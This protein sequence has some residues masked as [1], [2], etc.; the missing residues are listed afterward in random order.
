MKIVEK[1]NPDAPITET[2]NPFK[3]DLITGELKTKERK[4]RKYDKK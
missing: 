3:W 2:N 4:R 1:F